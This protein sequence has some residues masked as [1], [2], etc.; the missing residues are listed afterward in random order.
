MNYL[1]EC[2]KKIER[3]K[4]LLEG[5][6]N[7]LVLLQ[8]EFL[9]LKS[10]IFEIK[11]SIKE[12]SNNINRTKKIIKFLCYLIGGIAVVSA[13]TLMIFKEDIITN[14]IIGNSFS[15]LLVVEIVIIIYKYE[16][17]T[18][19]DLNEKIKLLKKMD[20]SSKK[21]EKEL[22]DKKNKCSCIENNI[23]NLENEIKLFIEQEDNL[24]NDFLNFTLIDQSKNSEK[25][26]DDKKNNLAFVKHKS[27]KLNYPD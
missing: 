21:K 19:K 23:N 10:S 15:L 27:R 25:T 9:K 5:E 2:N 7:E 18:K 1:S 8:E 26:Y 4:I 6:N 24:E 14:I 11:N 16:L 20:A 13:F 12:I 17:E 3:L 22:A